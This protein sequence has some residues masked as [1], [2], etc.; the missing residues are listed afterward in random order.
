MALY[1][2]IQMLISGFL[3][4]RSNFLP[5]TFAI[6]FLQNYRRCII[7]EFEFSAVLVD[8]IILALFHH[9]EIIPK[10]LRKRAHSF[11]EMLFT[12]QILVA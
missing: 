11:V 4:D 12:A 6:E 1:H 8:S 7:I 3:N 9:I 5:T 10:W 2:L